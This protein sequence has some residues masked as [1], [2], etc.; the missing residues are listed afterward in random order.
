M[1]NPR[2]EKK[3]NEEDEEIDGKEEKNETTFCPFSRDWFSSG[4]DFF[5]FNSWIF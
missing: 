1:R 5:I 2:K 4:K 3:K